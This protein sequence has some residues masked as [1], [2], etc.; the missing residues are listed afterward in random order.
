MLNQWNK[1]DAFKKISLDTVKQSSAIGIITMPEF[2][3]INWINGGRAV[4]RLWLMT[5]KLNIAL[6][7]IS[8]PLFLY[9][10]LKFGGEENIPQKNRH[11]LT[12]LH[13]QLKSIFPDLNHHEGLFLFRLSDADLPSIRSLRRPL[14]EMYFKIQ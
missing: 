11:E 9:A 8:A 14:N 5:S 4:Q 7:P 6:Q 3:D 2:D 13:N 10:Q 12:Q 1:G